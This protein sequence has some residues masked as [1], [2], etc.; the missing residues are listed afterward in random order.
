VNRCAW[1]NCDREGPYSINEPYCAEHLKVL[2]LGEA[3]KYKT[4]ELEASY[5]GIDGLGAVRRPRM[6]RGDR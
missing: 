2:G 5:G 4:G 3:D 6:A 1:G